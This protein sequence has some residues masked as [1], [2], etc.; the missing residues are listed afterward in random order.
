[1][2]LRHKKIAIGETAFSQQTWINYINKRLLSLYFVPGIY[3][4]YT[5][6]T[7][8]FVKQMFGVRD[9]LETNDCEISLSRYGSSMVSVKITLFHH[10]FIQ[11]LLYI[12]EF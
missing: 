4:T 2:R 6:V 12:P 10:P 11:F 9:S 5:F 1:M 7:K 8:Q 3:L